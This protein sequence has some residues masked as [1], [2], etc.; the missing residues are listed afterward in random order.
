M[1][2][3]FQ[4]ASS[5]GFRKSRLWRTSAFAAFASK[6]ASSTE[7]L[8]SE[9]TASSDDSDNRELASNAPAG[10]GVGALAGI[11]WPSGAASTGEPPNRMLEVKARAQR[12]GR[13]LET[14]G[15]RGKT[16]MFPHARFRSHPVH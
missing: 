9:T 3:V 15:F 13:S 5:V 1:G 7:G 4:L 12:R 8:R 2:I 14:G 6:R 16:S 11:S 10:L